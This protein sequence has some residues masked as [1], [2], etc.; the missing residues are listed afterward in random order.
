MKDFVI[1]ITKT[2]A[3][4]VVIS[5]TIATPIVISDIVT[6]PPA[7]SS[8]TIAKINYSQLDCSSDDDDL[9]VEDNQRAYKEMYSKWIQV[10]KINRSLKIHVDELRKEIDVLKRAVINYE[11][12]AVEKE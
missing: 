3:T 10:C 2:V 11:F 1:T 7:T 12:L 9:S 6:T 5:G 4:H 8:A